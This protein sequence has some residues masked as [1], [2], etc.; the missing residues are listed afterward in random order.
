MTHIISL[1]HACALLQ[2]SS[3]HTGTHAHLA[4]Q[5]TFSLDGQPFSFWLDDQ[6]QQATQVFIPSQTPHQFAD[7]TGQFLT[8]L[9][10]ADCTVQYQAQLQQ[11]LQQYFATSAAAPDVPASVA[12]FVQALATLR[13]ISD[14]RIRQA[15]ALIQTTAHE[16]DLSA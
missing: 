10:D 15:L 4:H 16:P 1:S 13:Q 8:L 7:Q 12:K 9:I 5:W 2:S 11:L 14:V 3:L 6:W